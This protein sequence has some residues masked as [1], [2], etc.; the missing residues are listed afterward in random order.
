MNSTHDVRRRMGPG[1]GS[2]PSPTQEFATLEAREQARQLLEQLLHERAACESRL[3]AR[4]ERDPIK[5]VTGESAYDR[6]IKLTQDVLAQADAVLAGAG[7]AS[8][9]RSSAVA[10]SAPASP[11]IE[12]S[13]HPAARG[14]S[15]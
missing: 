13:R 1:G 7:E 4:G 2:S 3:A 5:A 8:A 11:T 10:R 9:T 14:V 15:A 6:A 12:T